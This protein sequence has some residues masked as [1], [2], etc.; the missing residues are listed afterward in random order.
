MARRMMMEPRNG[1]TMDIDD[2]HVTSPADIHARE[3]VR[4]DVTGMLVPVEDTV[5][6]LGR[7]VSP[8]GRK[9]LLR[10]LREQETAPAGEVLVRPE[11]WSRF[12]CSVLDSVVLGALSLVIAFV[13]VPMRRDPVVSKAC[14]AAACFLYYALMHAQFGK[15]L[16]KMAGGFRVVNLDG[17]RISAYTAFARAFWSTGIAAIIG[18]LAS[19]G[20]NPHAAN[21]LGGV[22]SF[23]NCIFLVAD[24]EKNRALHDRLAGTRVVMD[25][26]YV[27]STR[28]GK[29][30]WGMDATGDR[31]RSSVTPSGSSKS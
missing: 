1:H 5:E 9:I 19:M 28:T 15:T 2:K 14:I 26:R 17:T 29:G 20:R 25:A 21:L 12:V 4:C 8:E 22:Y 30:E 16:G 6:V 31:F 24:E 7:R 23:A 10:E 18:L 13:L 11:F 3:M 27:Q